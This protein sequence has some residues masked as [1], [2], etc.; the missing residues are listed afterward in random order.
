M[1]ISKKFLL[2]LLFIA[3][4]VTA[5]IGFCGNSGVSYAASADTDDG[6]YFEEPYAAA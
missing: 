3:V 4:A 5:M 6:V 2:H 1:K